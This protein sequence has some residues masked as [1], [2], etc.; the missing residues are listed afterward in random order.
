MRGWSIAGAA[1]IIVVIIA[2][3]AIGRSSADNDDQA[4]K[5]P[6]HAM[7]PSN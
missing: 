2:A 7:N 1:I 4:D 6:P 3:F 5:A